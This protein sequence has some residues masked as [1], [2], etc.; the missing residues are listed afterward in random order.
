MA[1]I[2]PLIFLGG[3]AF[4]IIAMAVHFSGSGSLNSI[5]SKTVGDG[6]HGTARWATKQEIQKTYQHIPFRPAQWREGKEL[7]TAQGLV[8]GCIG[9]RPLKKSG[10]RR[11]TD[12]PGQKK[13]RK[14]IRAIVDTD[15][16]H[17]LMIGASGVGKTC[18]LYTSDA[19]DDL[20]RAPAV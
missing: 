6:Q 20:T 10:T 4:L 1:Q 12:K 18:L 13:A 14:P 17:C 19:A 16:I 2:I 7:P 3:G 8:L 15:D 5:K 11:L 9:G